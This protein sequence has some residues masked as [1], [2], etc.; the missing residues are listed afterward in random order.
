MSRVQCHGSAPA[1]SGMQMP[2]G[3][4]WLSNVPCCCQPEVGSPMSPLLNSRGCLGCTQ[5]S[6]STL[7]SVTES[8]TA[9]SQCTVS[10]VH[11]DW[12][13]PL[14]NSRRGWHTAGAPPARLWTCRISFALHFASLYK[15]VVCCN[16]TN[17]TDSLQRNAISIAQN[18]FALLVTG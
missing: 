3:G 15:F 13:P 2:Q 16:A 17:C 1:M 14:V 5:C 7:T 8:I 4:G 11:T 12:S 18:W 10:T 6:H 9:H